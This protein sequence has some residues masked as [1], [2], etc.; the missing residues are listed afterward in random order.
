VAHPPGRATQGNLLTDPGEAGPADEPPPALRDLADRLQR[1]AI[2]RG[3]NVGTAESCTGGLLGH[4]ITSIP[5]SS[6]YY[7]GGVISYSDQVKS[8]LLGVSPDV[9]ARHGAVSAQVAM[10]MAE[11]LRARL[12]CDLAVAVTGVAGPDGGTD[13]KP[14]GLT[15]V[16]TAGPGG[17]TV[18][19][20]IW[21][22]DRAANKV[23]SA[24]LALEMLIAGVEAAQEPGR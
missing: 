14:V 11:G 12:G 10:A 24:A 4:A 13:A 18:R 16:A 8:D 21:N 22:G 15:Y 20:Q 6:G 19:R 3:V 5:G 7:L 2:S 17:S 23:Q 1:L 9:L